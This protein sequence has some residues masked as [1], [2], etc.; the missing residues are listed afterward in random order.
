MKSSLFRPY[1]S[2][3]ARVIELYT[4]SHLLSNTPPVEG[5]PDVTPP[6]E[7]DTDTDPEWF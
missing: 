4:E 7:D 6:A 1:E 2:P 5:A 3:R